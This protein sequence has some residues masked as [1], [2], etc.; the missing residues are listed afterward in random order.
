MRET[1]IDNVVEV[2]C[3]EEFTRKALELTAKHCLEDLRM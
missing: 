3:Y 2:L 1:G